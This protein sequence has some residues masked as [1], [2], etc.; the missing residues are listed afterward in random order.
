MSPKS[1]NEKITLHRATID[2]A[3]QCVEEEMETL[4]SLATSVTWQIGAPDRKNPKDTDNIAAFRLAE[5]IEDR[6]GSTAFVS[7]LRFV[8][9]GEK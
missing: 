3:I 6:C 4:F 5:L 2:Y 8:L 9:L 7:N 1:E